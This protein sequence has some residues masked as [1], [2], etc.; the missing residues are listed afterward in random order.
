MSAELFV[1]IGQDVYDISESI[2]SVKFSETI[3]EGPSKLSFK[4]LDIGLKIENGSCVYFKYDGAEIFYGYIFKIDDGN[5]PEIDCTAY[6]QLRYLKVKKSFVLNKKTA[7]RFI[8]EV[9]YMFKMKWGHIADTKYVIPLT[10]YS[11]QTF[12]DVFTDIMKQTFVGTNE[13]YIFRDEFGKVSL[14]NLKELELNLVIGDSSLCYDYSRSFSI[15]GETY[16]KITYLNEEGERIGEFDD[17]ET[18]K[19]WGVL[20]KYEV[21]K[22]DIEPAQ[23]EKIGKN[24]LALYNKEEQTLDIKCIGDKRVR[25]GSSFYLDIGDKNINRNAIVKSVSHEFTPVHTMD[26]EVMI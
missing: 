24:I 11:S 15:D 1:K 4:M 25:A 16:N 19:K 6:D 18:Q 8:K 13:Y 7:G 2:T 12:L 14:R 22:E 5:G 10:S 9:C 26:L 23:L 3:N 21:L 17:L 20:K